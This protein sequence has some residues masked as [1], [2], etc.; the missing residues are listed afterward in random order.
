MLALRCVSW[1][2]MNPASTAL[3]I[4]LSTSRGAFSMAYCHSSFC[5]AVN[6][7]F[8]VAL[9]KPGRGSRP[10]HSNKLVEPEI[11]DAPG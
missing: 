2:T 7:A 8:T 5:S 9:V 4:F 6:H 1:A 10:Y 11:V 3:S